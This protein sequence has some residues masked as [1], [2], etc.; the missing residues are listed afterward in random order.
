MV[1]SAEEPEP[2]DENLQPTQCDQVP[3]QI[4]PVPA[5]SADE[6][7]NGTDKERHMDCTKFVLK[8][9]VRRRE[10]WF[11][12]EYTPKDH[13]CKVDFR[14]TSDETSTLPTK[15]EH[16]DYE[17]QI[18]EEDKSMDDSVTTASNDMWVDIPEDTPSP[19]DKTP[20]TTSRSSSFSSDAT[21][22]GNIPETPET[23]SKESLPRI[24]TPEESSSGRSS[25]EDATDRD[26]EGRVPA[27]ETGEDK[28][29]LGKTEMDGNPLKGVDGAELGEITEEK[30]DKEKEED[31]REEYR[32]FVLA[33]LLLS[34]IGA[35]IF[36]IFRFLGD[37]KYFL[38]RCTYPNTTGPFIPLI[39]ASKLMY[40]VQ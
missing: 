14:R 6:Q 17:H 22:I 10:R 23:S 33:E 27:K 38:R 3:N 26:N 32:L 40:R 28:V 8:K 2:G 13:Y 25:G 20:E 5:A 36:S 35:G 16:K 37:C 30:V 39:H 19:Q 1:T 4:D 24:M 12:R 9:M 34:L 21:T 29:S 18:K 11:K 15:P 7:P 31:T